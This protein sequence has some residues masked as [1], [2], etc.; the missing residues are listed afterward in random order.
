MVPEL[1]ARVAMKSHVLLGGGSVEEEVRL[2]GRE[3]LELDAADGAAVE[4]AQAP[5]GLKL[6][7]PG[8]LLPALPQFALPSNLLLPPGSPPPLGLPLLLA[9][10]PLEDGGDCDALGKDLLHPVGALLQR[11][12]PAPETHQLTM[13]LNFGVR[14]S[15]QTKVGNLTLAVIW[16]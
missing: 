12:H 8:G 2:E 14:S 16:S 3:G 4:A 15:S 11:G 7:V 9:S 1:Y 10:S 6:E 5:G 13:E